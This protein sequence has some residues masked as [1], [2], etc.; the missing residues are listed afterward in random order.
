M[1]KK[2]PEESIHFILE[3]TIFA[4]TWR[5]EQKHDKPQ[6]WQLEV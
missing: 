6:S 2:D 3:I 5:N 4:L 1:D